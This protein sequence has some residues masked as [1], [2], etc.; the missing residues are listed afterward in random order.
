MGSLRRGSGVEGRRRFAAWWRTEADHHLPLLY[1]PADGPF[2]GCDAWA[3]THAAQTP[4]PVDPAPAGTYV[5]DGPAHGGPTTPT[6]T[7]TTSAHTDDDKETGSHGATRDRGNARGTGPSAAGGV[8]GLGSL[9]ERK[10]RSDQ[11]KADQTRVAA[12]AD[13]R[14]FDAYQQAQDAMLRGQLGNVTDDKW[15]NTT[16]LADIAATVDLAERYAGVSPYAHATLTNLRSEAERRGVDL[17]PPPRQMRRPRR[18]R[19]TA[20]TT[21]PATT[22]TSTDASPNTSTRSRTRRR[23]PIG[24]Q[25]TSSR[26]GAA[27]K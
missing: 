15:W 1:S 6:T 13:R 3:G 14:Q 17:T 20:S 11:V 24:I 10:A 7:D 16:T 2:R 8:A 21:W 25:T 4:Q 23:L 9:R 26:D 18:R 12:A 27:P 5:A 19:E 22:T